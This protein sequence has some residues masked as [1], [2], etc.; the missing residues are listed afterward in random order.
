MFQ[1]AITIKCPNG[2]EPG[3][4]AGRLAIRGITSHRDAIAVYIIRLGIQVTALVLGKRPHKQRLYSC[5]IPAV[6]SDRL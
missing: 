6:S 4:F 2:Y 1:I 3:K 5:I